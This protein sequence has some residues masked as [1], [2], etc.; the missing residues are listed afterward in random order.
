MAYQ[1]ERILNEKRRYKDIPYDLHPIASAKL[2]DLNK[3]SFET[4]YLP[5]AVA[6]DIL[7]ENDRSYE[8]QLAATKMIVSADEPTPTVLGLLTIGI[9]PLDFLPGAYIQFLRFAG[10]THADPITDATRIDG[11]VTDMFRRTDDKLISHNRVA[12]DITSGPTEIRRQLYPV[13]GLQQLV[14]NAVMHRS[15]EATNAPIHVNWF[16]DRIE[17]RNPGGAFGN[18]TR[19]N[20]GQPGVLDY[21]NPNLA[22]ALRVMGLVQR[23]GVGIQIARRELEKN[24]NPPPS[25][26]V[27]ANH[28][29]VT[30]GVS[31]VGQQSQ[32]N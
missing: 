14:R 20:F 28:V 13:A 18:V 7:A 6:P 23:F 5:K 32:T 15:Y 26:E 10:L 9:R 11:A 16:D 12:I 2:T 4:D 17:I 3:V 31:P 1:D 25:F 22:E 21:R 24:G 30:V 27:A 29:F 8:Q 19:E